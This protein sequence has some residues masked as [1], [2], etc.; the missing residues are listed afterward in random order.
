MSS[1]YLP[2]CDVG[3]SGAHKLETWKPWKLIE[4]RKD[5]EKNYYGGP[6]GTHQ[7]SVFRTVPSAIPDPYT[8]SSQTFWIP[9]LISGSGKATHFKFCT[10]IHRIDRNKS[11]LK[12]SGKVAVGVLRESRKYLGHPYGASRGHFW[13][14][15][16]FLFYSSYFGLILSTF[17]PTA[18]RHDHL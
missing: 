14:S 15:S 12:I 17:R 11:P 4:T 3:E 13:D 5:R 7:R 16:A 1:V 6:I 2:V 9:P 8:A 10:H 18:T